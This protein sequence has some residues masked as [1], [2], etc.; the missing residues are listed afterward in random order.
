MVVFHSHSLQV[1]GNTQ[2][3][4]SG[5]LGIHLWYQANMIN[6]LLSSNISKLQY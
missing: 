5:E 1:Y 3:V 4:K 2:D 6:V